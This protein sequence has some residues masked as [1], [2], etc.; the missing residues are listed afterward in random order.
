MLHFQF[1][2][3]TSL[4][5]LTATI[6]CLIWPLRYHLRLFSSVFTRILPP[7]N[8]L[9]SSVL[10]TYNLST[11]LLV[12]IYLFVTS[13]FYCYLIKFHLC[14][15]TNTNQYTCTVTN[16]KTVL[17]IITTI[18]LLPLAVS[19]KIN[20]F[21]ITFYFWKFCFVSLSMNLLCYKKSRYL[22]A[23]ASTSLILLIWDISTPSDDTPVFL[24]NTSKPYFFFPKSILISLLNT[25][26][27][28]INSFTLPSL[29]PKIFKQSI[30]KRWFNFSPFFK[31]FPDSTFPKHYT[32]DVCSVFQFIIFFLVNCKI[33]WETCT[34]WRLQNL[35][36]ENHI[37]NVFII[38]IITI[39]SGRSCLL[40]MPDR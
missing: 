5:F 40:H 3:G 38:I 30:N 28:E 15:F 34:N 1:L 18:L 25:Y 26:T 6:K 16:T 19:F 24:F 31:L 27:V 14:H 21:L 2:L 37:I 29:F 13:L 7:N 20:F 10:D 35:E 36:M 4:L 12:H 8:F 17:A 33:F 11:P 39:I 9:P 22:Y 23:F 32:H